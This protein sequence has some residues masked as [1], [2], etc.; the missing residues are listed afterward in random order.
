EFCNFPAATH[1]G[2]GDQMGT[3]EALPDACDL[4]YSP[5]C[6]CDG[7]TYGNECAAH[8]EGVSVASQGECDSNSDDSCGGIAGLSCDKGEFCNYPA[9][10]KCGS[11]DQMGSCEAVPEVCAEIYAPV[12]GCDDK[13]YENECAAHGAGVSVASEGE[14]DVD[15]GGRACGGLAGVSCGTQAF[16]NYPKD[17]ACGAADQMGTCELIPEACDGN[18]APVCGCDDNTYSN[19][20]EAHSAGVS[21]A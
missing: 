6:G 12:C 2:S 20:C 9:E 13:T 1:C 19:E 14:C 4:I 17:A 11:G 21:V 15:P 10:T 5:V 16:C 18:Y 3:C 7:K 8:I